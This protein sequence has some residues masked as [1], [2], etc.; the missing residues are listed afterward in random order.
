MSHGVQKWPQF[1]IEPDFST[2]YHY[3]FSSSFAK[4]DT[5]GITV[6]TPNIGTSNEYIYGTLVMEM[7]T[8]S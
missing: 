2:V 4:G 1:N 6:H 7:D 3:D 8:S 5:I